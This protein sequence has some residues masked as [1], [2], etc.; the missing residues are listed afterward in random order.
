ML[1]IPIRHYITEDFLHTETLYSIS[2]EKKT[3]KA[4]W[5]LINGI[6]WNT[7]KFL[8]KKYIYRVIWYILISK[9]N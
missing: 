4:W 9:K 7:T 3:M 2:D 5:I 6:H 1:R 8:D